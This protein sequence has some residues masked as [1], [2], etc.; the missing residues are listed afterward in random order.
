MVCQ[1]S[2]LSPAFL[3]GCPDFS[4]CRFSSDV[5]TVDDD[6]PFIM[7]I[8][9]AEAAELLGVLAIL[10]FVQ[11]LLILVCLPLGILCPL[12]QVRPCVLVLDHKLR[13]A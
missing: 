8:M 10:A 7:N 1:L 3:L 6:L 5:V 2:D 11:P 4:P 12:L 9:L 13:A